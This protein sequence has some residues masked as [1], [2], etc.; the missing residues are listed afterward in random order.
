MNTKP[1]MRVVKICPFCNEEYLLIG[2]NQV[3]ANRTCCRKAA[4]FTKL[5]ENAMKKTFIKPESRVRIGRGFE[6]YS[7]SYQYVLKSKKYTDYSNKFLKNKKNIDLWINSVMR[8]V[9]HREK[10]SLEENI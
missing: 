3:K 6:N 2:Y 4:C 10:I 8:K 7:E 9:E 5:H 1:K